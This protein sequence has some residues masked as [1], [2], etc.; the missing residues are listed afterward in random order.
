MGRRDYVRLKGEF[1][2]SKFD[3][4]IHGLQQDMEVPDHV[5]VK[6]TDTL[7][8]LPD[9][10]AERPSHTFA[11][12]R[13]WPVA[14]AATLVIGTVS[15]STAAYMQWSRGLE[16]RLHTTAEQR[17]ILEDNQM[18]SFIGQSVTQGNVTVTAQQSIVDNHFAHLS[19]KVEGYQAKD[20]EQPGFSD[21]TITV[22]DNEDYTGGWSAS[23]YNGLISGPDGRAVHPDGTPLKEDEEISYILEDGSMEFQVDMMSDVKGAFFD[24][25]IHVEL[26]NLG[27]YGGKAEDVI[28]EEEGDWS[29]DWTLQGNDEVKQYELNAPLGDSG[30]TI[31]QAELSPI[32]VSVSYDFPKQKETETG[33]DENG[34]EFIHTTFKD[35]PAFTGVRLKDG[36]V[37]TGISGAG[38]NGYT[39]EDS[40][41]YESLTALERVIDVDQV[42]SLLFVKSYP[43]SRQPLTEEN[44]YF[45]SVE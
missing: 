22:G 32:S 26:K 3:D 30:A 28:V 34:E 37:Y 20:G 31:I 42:E 39:A 6:Y 19:F 1:N 45:V 9:R 12:R 14:A 21:I 13:I 10:Q 5:W 44:L 33:T 15:V 4:M 29:F 25:P 38:I 43:D 16:E 41:I 35:A 40:D 7:S 23:F 27:I 24:Q 18:S 36:T 11:K 17:Q 2:M 8:K